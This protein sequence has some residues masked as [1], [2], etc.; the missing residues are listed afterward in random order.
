M[1]FKLGD[2]EFTYPEAGKA[3][4]INPGVLLYRMTSG[5]L[6]VDALANV[7]EQPLTELGYCVGFLR[8]T[9]F[10]RSVAKK[11]RNQSAAEDPVEVQCSR[12]LSK[13][14]PQRRFLLQRRANLLHRS[15]CSHCYKSRVLFQDEDRFLTVGDTIAE[16][17]FCASTLYN[18]LHT[19]GV[20]ASVHSVVKLS[21]L[22]ACTRE[23]G[24]VVARR[25]YAINERVGI[26]TV[27]G[28]VVGGGYTVTCDRGHVKEMPADALE[29]SGQ[30]G[31]CMGRGSQMEV[32]V[33]DRKMRIEAFARIV[34]RSVSAVKKRIKGGATAE[35]LL[36]A[37]R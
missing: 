19:L 8:V 5:L 2:R 1:K 15:G 14:K 35:G 6:A 31:A 32:T 13:Y 26:H 3:Y 11:Q 16:T 9:G 30:C 20:D 24:V 25:K 22:R 34:G 37:R 12:C 4:R 18:R 27:Q 28:Y 10:S 23:D 33:G 7:S 17:G 29:Q 36:L 21:D